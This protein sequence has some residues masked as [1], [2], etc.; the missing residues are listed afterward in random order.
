MI[1][2]NGLNEYT[3]GKTKKNNISSE[4]K[5]EDFDLGFEEGGETRIYILDSHEKMPLSKNGYAYG[6]AFVVIEDRPNGACY[7]SEYH[8]NDPH[9]WA[10]VRRL[11]AEGHMNAGNMID[12]PSCNEREVTVAV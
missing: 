9:M 12:G 1:I 8:V 4:R 7:R 6:P 3:N 5:I 2:R 10:W 11:I